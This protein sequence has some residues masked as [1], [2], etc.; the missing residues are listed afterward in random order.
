MR[1]PY[2]VWWLTIRHERSE[3]KGWAEVRKKSFEFKQLVDHHFESAFFA[4]LRL[5]DSM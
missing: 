5:S 2:N 4:R 3:R 1:V